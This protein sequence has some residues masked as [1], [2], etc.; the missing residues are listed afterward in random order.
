MSASVVRGLTI[1]KRVIVSPEPDPPPPAPDL[2]PPPIAEP[3]QVS[4]QVPRA[5]PPAAPEP[6]SLLA[7]LFSWTRRR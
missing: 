1:A 3:E 2:P 6:A 5:S 4:A 7:T